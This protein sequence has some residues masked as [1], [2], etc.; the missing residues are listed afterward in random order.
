MN[1]S[2]PANQIPP[3][4][5]RPLTNDRQTWLDYWKAIGKSWRTEPEISIERQK[6]LEHW[7]TGLAAMTLNFPSLDGT[8]SSILVVDA[9]DEPIEVDRVDLNRADFE[10][11]LAEYNAENHLFTEERTELRLV[12]SRENLCRINLAHLPMQGL[13]FG[14]DFDST[15][16]MGAPLYEVNLE[17]ANLENANLENAHLQAAN[18]QGTNLQ[19]A[20]LQGTLLQGADL[21]RADLQRADLRR[22]I[23]QKEDRHTWPLQE[24]KLRE[25]DLRG[26]NLQGANLQGIDLQDINLQGADLCGAN[27]QGADLRGANL[28]GA[29]L[30]GADLRGANLQGADLRRANLQGADLSEII[31]EKRVGRKT[32]KERVSSN[33][34]GANLEGA[35]LQR[36][37]LQKANI[38]RTIF[39]SA[40]L[41]EAHLEKANPHR[42]NCV[43][44]PELL[45]GQGFL[46]I[47]HR[48][49]NYSV[50]IYKTDFYQAT[51]QKAWLQD[52]DL[53]DADFQ[54]AHL[55][56]AD[57]QRAFLQGADLQNSSLQRANLQ[58]ARL[59]WALLQ[60]AHLEY[61]DLQRAFLQG[62]DLQNSS[63]QGANLQEAHLENYDFI[64]GV[65]SQPR[66]LPETNLQGANLQGA[67]LQGANL[68]SAKFKGA[69]LERTRLQG[70]ILEGADFQ[71]TNLRQTDLKGIDLQKANLQ[72]V[73]LQDQELEGTNFHQAILRGAILKRAFLQEANLSEAFLQEAHLDEAHLEDTDL[74]RAHIEGC[75]LSEAFFSRGTK[76]RDIYL[77]DKKESLLRQLISFL[78]GIISTAHSKQH[79]TKQF[80]SL[81]GVHWGEAD[82]SVVDW[83]QL[84]MI[85]EEYQAHQW[86]RM[87]R[88]AVIWQGFRTRLQA[89]KGAVRANRQL[90]VALQEQGLNEEAT[91]FAYR[92]QNLQRKVFW[93]QRDAG[94]WFFSLLLARLAG[95]GY[96]MSLILRAY[97][98][99]VL[100]CAGAYFVLGNGALSWPEAL[101]TSVTAFH[102]RV[103]SNASLS[104]LQLWVTAFEAVAGFV[105]EGI[106]IA[107]LTQ[108][109]FGK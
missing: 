84:Y 64:L 30:Q 65:R 37:N 98:F 17:N 89:Y 62:A 93:H 31:V 35:D 5:P 68:Q 28:Q 12:V 49:I 19:A 105:I 91:I 55:D 57:L 25:T 26:A 6:I 106:F 58:E 108:R 21:R 23:F 10:W 61:A 51:L 34:Q 95:Y 27:L 40:N 24:I 42:V 66:R 102:G 9:T 71:K 29:N 78:K 11:L 109:F 100:L 80:I 8:T 94:R 60:G 101:L 90:A 50:T 86:P 73:D 20:N 14:G 7:V 103:F 92:A 4:H 46:P 72:E 69:I 70:A 77:A 63:L 52:A 107:M 74:Q 33:L 87:H 45:P 76:L 41:R 99:I 67:N 3:V 88:G 96:R 47:M 39:R 13:C 36:A 44:A 83:R 56:D 82:L 15:G 59:Q 22:A 18:L 53:R 1:E 43:P 75:S 54:E 32:I 104:G 48:E 79:D 16:S 97:L 2:E 85:R 81:A 38:E